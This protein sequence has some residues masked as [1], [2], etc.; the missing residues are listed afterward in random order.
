[1]LGDSLE[2]GDGVRGERETQEGKDIC[3]PMVDSC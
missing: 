1:M 2:E 3:I